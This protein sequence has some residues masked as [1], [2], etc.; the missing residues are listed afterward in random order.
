[1]TLDKDDGKIQKALVAL[2]PTAVPP[3]GTKLYETCRENVTEDHLWLSVML[4]PDE[5]SFTRLQR[6]YCCF[7]ILF[8]AM[9][10]NAMFFGQNNS[11]GQIKFGP[12]KFSLAGL[13]ISLISILMTTPPIILI[14]F[15]FRNSRGK[16]LK[17]T[18]A[19]DDIEKQDLIAKKKTKMLPHGCVYVAWLII[20]LAILASGFF[21]I[22]YSMEWGKHKSEE[23]LK[24]FFL[25]W[26]QSLLIVDPIKVYWYMIY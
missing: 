2:D 18:D 13:Y 7:M 8:L 23:W 17:H 16:P 25:S 21:V 4:R 19:F 11:V 5:S 26:F 10:T 3:F 14:T 12:L 1:M 22:L 20:F 9:I 15:L 24:C 6:M